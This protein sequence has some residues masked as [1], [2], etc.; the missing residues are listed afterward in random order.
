MSARAGAPVPLLKLVDAFPNIRV[1]FPV[2]IQFAPDHP[3]RIYVV[4]QKLGQVKFF[5]NEPAPSPP[6]TF[7]D[8]SSRITTMG[9]EA[10][11]LALAFHPDYASNGYIFVTYTSFDGF[12]WHS[13]VS[14]FTRS[15]SDPDVIDDTTELVLFDVLEDQPDHNVHRLAFGPDA[16]LYIAAGDGGSPNQDVEGD[17][18]NPAT[19]KGSI[20]RIDVNAADPPLN[21]AIPQDNPFARNKLGYREEVFC[22]GLRNPWRFSFGPDG[23]L[24]VGDVGGQLREEI[25]LAT[26]GANL[27]WNLVEGTHCRTSPDCLDADLTPPVVEYPHEVTPDG[28]HAVIAGQVFTDPRCPALYGAFIYTDHISANFWAI[29]YADDALVANTNVLPLSG[30]RPT[31]IARTPDGELLV[32]DYS[33]SGRVLRLETVNICP[34]DFA[35]PLGQLDFT[36]VTTFLQAFLDMIPT[37]DLAEPAGVFDFSDVTRFLAKFVAGCH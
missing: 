12:C 5:V 29:H 17:A 16:C 24:W 23:K 2:D 13:V 3:D 35:P 8:L 34:A 10:G 11:I 19:L 31:A 26:P 1:Q 22:Y 33:S 7:L 4:L 9:P 18:Q 36:D 37:A 27:G 30:A 20:L 14:R 32:A 28:G 15:A 25:S 6:K 21:Y